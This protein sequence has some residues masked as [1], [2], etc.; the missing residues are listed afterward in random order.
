MRYRLLVVVA[1]VTAA[2][3]VSYASDKKPTSTADGPMKSYKKPTPDELKKKLTADQYSVTQEAAT[4]PA[5]HNQFWN[6]KRP[7]IYVDIVSGEPLFSSLEKFDSGCGWPSF[8]E[9]IAPTVEKT[10]SSHGMVRTEVRSKHADSHLGHL[11]DDGPG[12]T[13]K[14]YCI[15]SAALRFIPVDK[16]QA[17]GYGEQLA[18]FVAAGLIAAPKPRR[19]TAILAGGC[20]WGMEEIIRKLPGVVETTVGYSGGTVASPGY[21]QVSSGE[22]GH[23]ESVRIVFDPDKL[24]YAKLLD[25]F[26]RMHDPT[27]KNRQHGDVGTQ[28]RSAIFYTSDEQ[29]KVAEQVKAEFDHSGRFKQPIVTEISA[30]TPFYTAEDYHQKYLVKHPDGYTC[31]VLRD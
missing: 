9:S 8:T 14:R 15:N 13:H 6:E 25:N 19:E 5:F 30:A 24:S 29:R 26:F 27:T 23:A 3:V 18:P 11:F 28:Y 10:D 20:F 21:E 2:A 17:E 31:H 1:L 16:M 7:G 22:T 12:P 4:E